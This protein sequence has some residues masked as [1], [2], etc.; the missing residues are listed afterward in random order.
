MSQAGFDRVSVD[1]GLAQTIVKV[2]E[3]GEDGRLV[4]PSAVTVSVYVPGLSVL[5]AES[6]PLKANRLMPGSALK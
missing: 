2:I 6:R 1:V 5:N 3:R 4:A